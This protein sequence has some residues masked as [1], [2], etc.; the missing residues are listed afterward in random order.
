MTA[1][2][3]AELSEELTGGRSNVEPTR[4]FGSAGSRTHGK[5]FAMLVNG[6]LVVKLPRGRVEEL[7]AAGAGDRFDPGHGRLMR[8]W[9]SLA[10]A[11]DPTACRKLMAEAL[12]FVAAA[13][14]SGGRGVGEQD[15]REQP[16]HLGFAGHQAVQQP[17]EPDRLG[18]EVA[19]VQAR[20]GT[21]GVALVEDQVQHVQNHA[22]P[23]GPLGRWWQHE[24]GADVA[25]ALLGPADPLRLV[26]SGTRNAAAICAV[27]KPPTA[28]KVSASCDGGDKTG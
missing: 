8:E 5:T 24:P 1:D 11:A 26:A 9:V 28:R 2:L 15:Q 6:R 12:A 3:F 18:G 14:S 17:G 16:G 20:P 25:D 19:R 7:L 10:E 4:M 13:V 22:E 23:A 21:G 27:V